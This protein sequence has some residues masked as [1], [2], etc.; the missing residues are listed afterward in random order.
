MVPSTNHLSGNTTSAADFLGAWPALL[1]SSLDT[2][3]R[4]AGATEHDFLQIGSQMQE[5]YLR[6]IALSETAH[7]L[8]EVASGEGI[9]ALMDKLGQMLREMEAYIGQAQGRNSDSSATLDQVKTLLQKVAEP[10]EGFGKM[11]KQLYI[12]EVSIKIESTYLGQMEGEFLNLA[13]DVKKLSRQIKEKA[14]AVQDQRLLL[15][16]AITEIIADIHTVNANQEVKVRAA[17]SD[18]AASLSGLETVNERFSLLGKGISAVSEENANNISGIVQSMQ[19]HDIYRQQVE[20][21]IE[22]LEGFESSLSGACNE[23]GGCVNPGQE[24]IGKAGDVCELQEA[25]LQFASAELYTAV[26]SIVAN[27]RDISMQQERMGHEIYTQTGAID[28]SSTSFVDDVSQ[29]MAA[30]TDLLITCADTN[31]ELAEV[32]KGV[33]GTVEEI[34]RFVADIEDIGR[35]IIQVA[36]NSRIKAACTGEKGA[37]LSVL[38]KEI[39]DLSGEVVQRADTIT[40]TLTEIHGTT[41]VLSAKANSTEEILSAKLSGMKAELSETLVILEDMGA[42]LLSLLP[43]IQ[44]QI[45]A[46]TSEIESIAGSIDVHERT[47]AMA[48]EVLVNLQLVCS[49]SRALYPA[50]AAFKEDL[51]R[52]AE[53]YTMESERRIHE[54]IA[55]RHG[56]QLSKTQEAPAAVTS[57]DASEFGD[58]VDLF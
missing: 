7:R 55:G 30:I 47:K 31:S 54:G 48:N 42:E 5:I 10:L 3:R 20:H 50:S 29:H 39:G 22:A 44:N 35:D 2:L 52:M 51:R 9:R 32:T 21:V 15:S 18:T 26:A 56:V 45:N 49:Q 53:R 27:L 23:N 57:G 37:S 38:S 46:L 43:Q 1:S 11:S 6:S 17:I 8:V 33:T 40:A 34:T 12:L 41:D 25:Q 13:Q 14:N 16:S 58:N 28:A 24:L 36:L 19:I 4:L